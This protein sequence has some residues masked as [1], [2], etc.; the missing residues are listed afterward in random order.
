MTDT[1]DPGAWPRDPHAWPRFSLSEQ[2]L[3]AIWL[4]CYRA[5]HEALGLAEDPD[6][7]LLR[8]ELKLAARNL[9]VSVG[10]ELAERNIDPVAVNLGSVQ[11]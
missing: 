6:M 9:L 1:N 5:Q 10:S 3:V 11:L 8:A 7:R 2:E 4:M